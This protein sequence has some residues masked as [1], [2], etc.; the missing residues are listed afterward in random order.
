VLVS[1]RVVVHRIGLTGRASPGTRRGGLVHVGVEARPPGLELLA[2][3]RQLACQ[4]GR[5]LTLRHPAPQPSQGRGR[6]LGLHEDGTGEA[7]V[8][9]MAAPTPRGRNVTLCLE[10]PPIVAPAARALPARWVEGAF[11]PAGAAVIAP[12]VGYGD[13]DPTLIVPQVAR[14]LHMSQEFI[15]MYGVLNLSS[16]T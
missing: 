2:A 7:G 15:P 1:P 16:S 9:A 14:W 11:Q 3:P 5:G 4:A 10:P 12:Q 6:L 8:I 13:S